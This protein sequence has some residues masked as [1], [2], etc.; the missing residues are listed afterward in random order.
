MIH[1]ISKFTI[2]FFVFSFYYFYEPK[3]FAIKFKYDS[4]KLKELFFTQIYF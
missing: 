4:L 1:F 2:I 3:F